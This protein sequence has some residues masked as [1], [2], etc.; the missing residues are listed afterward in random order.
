MVGLWLDVMILKV[1]SNLD[2]SMRSTEHHAQPEL[3]NRS[4]QTCGASPTMEN[5]AKKDA[6]H[7]QREDLLHRPAWG[8]RQAA[9]PVAGRVRKHSFPTGCCSCNTIK[10]PQ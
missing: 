8:V 4:L 9:V 6:H 7:E 2:G 5:P 3:P 10:T 1:F